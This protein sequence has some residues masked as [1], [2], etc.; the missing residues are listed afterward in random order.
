VIVVGAW[1]TSS[2]ADVPGSGCWQRV[3]AVTSCA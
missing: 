2:S 3:R 1:S